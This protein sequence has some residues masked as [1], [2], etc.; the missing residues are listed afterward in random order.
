ML[1]VRYTH[2][3]LEWLVGTAGND[4]EFALESNEELTVRG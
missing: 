4:V 2:P 1:T 3:G